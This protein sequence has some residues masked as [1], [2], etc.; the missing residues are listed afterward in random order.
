MFRLE[1]WAEPHHDGSARYVANPA[2]DL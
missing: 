2:P 1:P